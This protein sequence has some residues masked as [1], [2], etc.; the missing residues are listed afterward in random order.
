MKEERVIVVEKKIKNW[1]GK[2]R[3]PVSLPTPQH[4]VFR[5]ISSCRRAGRRE[6]AAHRHARLPAAAGPWHPCPERE[7]KMAFVGSILHPREPLPP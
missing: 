4:W 2:Q 3:S 6:A 1:A 7:G 5:Q